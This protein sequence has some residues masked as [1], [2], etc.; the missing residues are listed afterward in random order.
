[1]WRITEGGDSKLDQIGGGGGEI[2]TVSA[3]STTKDYFRAEN[4]FIS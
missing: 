4:K 1:M 3:L 2:E